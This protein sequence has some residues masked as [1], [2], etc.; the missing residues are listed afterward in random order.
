MT[1]KEARVYLDEMS[2]YGSVLGLDVVRELLAELGD[3]Q[4]K[5]RFIHIAGTNGK[6][7]VLAL[8]SSVLSE[9]GFKTGRYTS[10][11]VFS[12]LERMQ[13]DGVW[14]SKTEFAELIE[15]VQKAIVRMETRGIS[16]PTV[17]E[18]ETAVAF[19][20]FCKKKCD[21]VVLETGLGGDLDATNVVANTEIAV[22]T[23]ISRDHMGF[24]GDSLE[25]IA[26]KKAGIIKPGCVVVSAAQQPEVCR[27]LKEQAEHKECALVFARP[28]QAVLL[29]E[30]Y[31]ELLFSYPF[32]NRNPGKE[33]KDDEESGRMQFRMGMTGCYQVDNAVTA[34]EAVRRL[35]VSSAAVRD[36]FARAEWPG[37]FTGIVQKPA[38]LIDGAHNVDAVKRLRESVERYFPGRQLFLIMGVF[39]DKEYRRMAE[40][41]APLAKQIYTVNLPDQ[42]RGLPAEELKEAFLPFCVG[43]VQAAGNISAAVSL[44][45]QEA[46][47]EDVI[48]ACGSLSYLGKVKAEVKRMTDG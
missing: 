6:G 14:I 42:K 16:S 37:R 39:R 11:A 7:S 25:E 2:K 38:F 19:L 30:N 15:E 3:P 35:P 12:D 40:I 17:F 43:E 1:Y 27:V 10:P 44:A 18:I 46:R 41:L 23:T 5:L 24:L 48:L 29:E 22:F 13:I 9:A 32:S 31:R 26:Q 47:E 34:L 21:Y 8:V 45:L 33:A 36:G 28:E 4:E 20:Y